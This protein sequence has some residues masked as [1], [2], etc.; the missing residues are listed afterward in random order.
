MLDYYELGR[1][2]YESWVAS[3]WKGREGRPLG[4][5]RLSQETQAVW[6]RIATT[7]AKALEEERKGA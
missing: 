6:I 1:K 4:W 5:Y 2:A 7:I 3:A